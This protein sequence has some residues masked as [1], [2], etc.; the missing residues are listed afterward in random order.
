[1]K[2]FTK[3]HVKYGVLMCFVVI[4]CLAL[5]ELT[6]NNQ[7]FEK[8]P[9]LMGIQMLMPL[10]IWYCGIKDKKDL[11]KGKISFKEG[12]TEGFKISL[13]F[14][15]LSPFVFMLYYFFINPEIVTKTYN[16]PTSSF[17]QIVVIDM[18]L[19]FISALVFGTL[20][21][22]IISFFLKTKKK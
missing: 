16:Q 6:G 2:Y 7:S 10:V 20:Y 11:Q 8:V 15:A 22:A 9:I 4:V 5:M 1:M 3:N 21:A 19:Q 14:A 17:A 13:I 12:V 18:I